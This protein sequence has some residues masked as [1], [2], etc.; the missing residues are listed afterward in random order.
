MTMSVIMLQMP[1]SAPQKAYNSQPAG[2][3]HRAEK[4][5]GGP[6][7]E[8]YICQLLLQL[9]QQQLETLKSWRSSKS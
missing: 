1:N 5:P 6:S 7:T 3:K 4:V 8:G 9:L 2:G